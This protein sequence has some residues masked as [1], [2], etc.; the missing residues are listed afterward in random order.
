MNFF[1][2]ISKWLIFDLVAVLAILKRIN[3]SDL[4]CG[5]QKNQIN[6]TSVSVR[7]DIQNIDHP[8]IYGSEDLGNSM[9]RGQNKGNSTLGN[10]CVFHRFLLYS[11]CFFQTWVP[12]SK[13]N[14]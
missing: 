5:D 11:Q 8:Q 3:G 14:E 13:G 10:F 2:N 12:H 9:G 7:N 6:E 4:H 1:G